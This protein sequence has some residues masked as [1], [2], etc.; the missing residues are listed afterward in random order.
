MKKF[1][2][3]LV[4]GFLFGAAMLPATA[5]AGTNNGIYAPYDSFEDMRAAYV[6]AVNRGDVEKQKELYDLGH[7]TLQKEIDTSRAALSSETILRAN[8]DEQYWISQFPNLFA[9]GNWIT[10]EAGISLSLNPL[11]VVRY[12]YQS[13]AA[14]GWN[15]VYSKYR[16]DYRWNNTSSMEGQY[17]CHW[18]NA[19]VKTYWN[20]EPY[21]ATFNPYN[22]N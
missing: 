15:S 11:S 10:R 3:K 18:R 21:K 7:S 1:L 20:L 6:D 22:C 16:K 8:Q 2:L 13:D 17:Y 14:R 19:K 4:A 9:S 5:F 12:G